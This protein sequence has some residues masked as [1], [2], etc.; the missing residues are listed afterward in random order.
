MKNNMPLTKT[1]LQN[2]LKEQEASIKSFIKNEFK[3]Y[4]IQLTKFLEKNVLKPI[5][6]LKDDVSVIKKDV[7][8]L[9]KDMRY[10][11]HEISNINRKIDASFA[12]GD[13]HAE[14]LGDHEKR[15]TKLERISP[16]TL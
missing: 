9:K 6:E 2:A 7:S 12:R 14:Q 13:R 10:V 16:S 8:K 1:D 3:Q 11:M 4:H 5:F 15:I